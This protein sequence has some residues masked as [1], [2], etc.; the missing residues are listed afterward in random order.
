MRSEYRRYILLRCL[1]NLLTLCLP[2]VLS[3]RSHERGSGTKIG[4]GPAA[5]SWNV[6]GA[7]KPELEPYPRTFFYLTFER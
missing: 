6:A 2:G 4:A 7:P 5:P 3:G 1:I